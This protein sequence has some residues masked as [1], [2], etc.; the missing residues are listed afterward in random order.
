MAVPAQLNVVYVSRGS[1]GYSKGFTSAAAVLCGVFVAVVLVAWGQPEDKPKLDSLKTT[2][3]GLGAYGT[4]YKL[5]LAIGGSSGEESPF[6]LSPALKA[7]FEQAKTEQQSSGLPLLPKG[8][9]SS[10]SSSP[11]DSSLMKAFKQA[12]QEQEAEKKIEKTK[13]KKTKK[14]MGSTAAAAAF[15]KAASK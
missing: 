10:A 13:Q 11:L 9:S 3:S 15:K 1:Q 4:D 12:Q 14:T 2:L 6:A 8:S 7:A 5:A